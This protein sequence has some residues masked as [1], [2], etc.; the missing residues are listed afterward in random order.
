MEKELVIITLERYEKM[1]FDIKTAE[2]MAN[3][4]SIVIDL[5]TEEIDCLK[6]RNGLNLCE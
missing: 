1:V 6:K 4:Q 3:N 2:D 5:L